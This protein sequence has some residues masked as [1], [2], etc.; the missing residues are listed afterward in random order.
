MSKL[1]ST[2]KKAGIAT[3]VAAC[4]VTALSTL[5]AQAD[6]PSSIVSIASANLG[7]G[8]CSTN[9]AG[10][11]GF[12]S[13]CNGEAWCA[14]FAKWVWQQA[15]V[16][17]S[18]LT[19]GAGS[20]AGYNGGLHT[21]P[22]V[23]DA[24]VFGYNGN[25]YA[26]HVAIVTAVGNGTVTS[27]GGNQGSAGLVSTDGPYSSSIGYSSYM[28]MYLSGYV[29]PIGGTVSTPAPAPVTPHGTVWDRGMTSSGT[30]AAHA[31]EIDT[32]GAITAIAGA[33]LPGGTMH[34][35]TIV[36]GSGVWDRTR[37]TD[38]T[39]TSSQQIDTTGSISQIASA[40]LPNG[41][42]HVLTV[43]NGTVW[44]RTRSS[45]G[46]WAA[47]A[48]EIDS[49]GSVTAISAA[50]LPDGTLHVDTVAGGNVWDRTLSSAGTWAAH[51]TEIDNNGGIGGVAATA[52]PNGVLHI[53][54][55]TNG[56]VWDRTLSAAGVWQAHAT[57]VDSTGSVDNLSAAALPNG[58]LQIDTTAGGTV[59][60]RT[61][62][63]AGAWDAHATELDTNGSIF[64]TY[65]AALPD[66][67]LHVGSAVN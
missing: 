10:G 36:P 6:T 60:E 31:G 28:G 43:V 30:W 37:N 25:G 57:D 29:T 63:A 17:V 61:L 27:I 53:D 11:T 49:T 14:D 50:G 1:N 3:I 35:D 51:S 45:A 62:S 56:Q 55:L 41:T 13:S 12:E 20:F 5:P 59:W 64:D 33:G 16:D 54:T 52:L 9:S 4:A 65:T 7:D 39:W 46:D 58:S 15:G 2:F 23:G 22:H 67:T 40:A 19:A 47:H 24:V 8:P 48:T 38:G 18:G 32:N 21:T 42:L 26:D 66:G 34:V 44:D